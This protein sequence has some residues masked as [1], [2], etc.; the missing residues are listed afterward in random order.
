MS[1]CIDVNTTCTSCG[2]D[3]EL[4]MWQSI[5][6]ELDPHLKPKLLD[7]SLLTFHCPLCGAEQ[8]VMYD[9]LY[10]DPERQYMIYLMIDHDDPLQE[11]N[12]TEFGKLAHQMVGYRLR[13]VTDFQRF[14]EKIFI[15][16]NDLDDRVL[17]VL[18]AILVKGV[19]EKH[20]IGAEHLFYTGVEADPAEATTT[21]VDLTIFAPGKAPSVVHISGEEGYPRAE[22]L[23]HQEL[24]VPK[25]ETP[26]WSQ[27]GLDYLDQL[28]A[29]LG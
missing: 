7:G 12:S 4:R 6:V 8:P 21:A 2:E 19:F 9:L 23:L 10:H 29:G 26:Y 1:K 18:R 28:R 25:F 24:K 5:N 27:V 17:E 11:L 14:L 13:I 15:F 20:Q 16:D 22:Q 3:S